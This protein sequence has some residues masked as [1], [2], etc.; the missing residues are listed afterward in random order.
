MIKWDGAHIDRVF[1]GPSNL[2]LHVWGTS[3]SI[4]RSWDFEE[5]RA[6]G[7]Y[8]NLEAPWRR[9]VIGFD[10]E[11]L[12]LD[13]TVEGDL[14]AWAWKDIDELEWSVAVGKLSRDRAD[15]V[16]KAGEDVVAL[17]QGRQWPFVDDWSKWRPSPEWSV[18][19]MPVGWDDPSL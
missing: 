5:D 7:W 12:V 14:S 2:R 13:L 4:I 8:V 18:P 11:D 19:T 9:T 1:P 15:S 16:R 17:L 3:Y 10:S 6:T